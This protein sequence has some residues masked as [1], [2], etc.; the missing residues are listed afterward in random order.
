M[1]NEQYM[2]IRGRMAGDPE[3]RFTPSGS[4]VAN[5]TIA[6]NARQFD[7]NTN[8]WKDKDAIF[9]RCAAWRD[10]AEN[11]VE[12]LTKGMAVIALV[13]LE[14]RSYDAKDGTK[15]TVTEA[16][17]ESIGPDLR[18][19]SAKVTRT[20]K[21]AGGQSN[22]SGFGSQQSAPPASNGSWTP[23]QGQS[24]GGWGAP[25]ADP[26]ASGDAGRGSAGG[27]QEGPF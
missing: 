17:I 1:A 16:K 6:A 26:W 23:D 9:W 12:S 4:A 21:G 7:K 2:T 20:Q 22:G 3:M 24:N 14:A 25:A 8:E 27:R 10:L 5:F 19:A 13:E 11:V 15:R 18:W